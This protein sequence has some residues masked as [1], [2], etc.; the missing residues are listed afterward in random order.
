MTIGKLIKEYRV[1]KNLSQPEL[2]V[3]SNIEQSYLSKIENDKSV[4][5]DE[6]FQAI[7]NALDMPVAD[8]INNEDYQAN[9]N[10]YNQVPLLKQHFEHQT[11][12]SQVSQRH[13]LYVCT[14]FMAL[15]LATFYSGWKASIFH[16]HIY[17]YESKGLVK[18]DEPIDIYDRNVADLIDRSLPGFDQKLRQLRFK[19]ASRN[20]TEYQNFTY[21]KGESYVQNFPDG[22]RLFRFDKNKRVPHPA[23]GVLQFLGILFAA[24]GAIGFIIERRIY[25]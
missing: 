20:T 14:L 3:K 5:S 10:I 23:N 19:L 21:Y 25:K 16:E 6:V 11:Q 22:R 17:V 8:F 13:F 15:G 4:P 12:L 9:P 18:P 24:I 7:L 1:S 2:S